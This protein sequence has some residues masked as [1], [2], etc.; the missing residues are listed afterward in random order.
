MTPV[1]LIDLGDGWY[2]ARENCGVEKDAETRMTERIHEVMLFASR[3][4]A[5][6]YD[7]QVHGPTTIR[8]FYLI[9]ADKLEITYKIKNDD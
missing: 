2:I 6:S 5:K 8:E 4:D 3:S 1:Y 9:P 7:R